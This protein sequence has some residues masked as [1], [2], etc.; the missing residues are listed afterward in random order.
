MIA[1]GFAGGEAEEVL[2]AHAGF[3]GL[4]DH[5]HLFVRDQ[6]GGAG[7]DVAERPAADHVVGQGGF[8]L[9]GIPHKAH[10]GMEMRF[11]QAEEFFQGF[12]VA[13]VLMQRVLKAELLAIQRLRPLG[14]L[15][16]AEDP[17]FHVLR[18]DHE[19]AE[20]RDDDVVDLGGA[21]GGGQGDVVDVDA[22]LAVQRDFL[23]KCQQAFA[24]PS[25]E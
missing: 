16:V 13:V 8:E 19:D 2:G 6:H 18:F 17:A 15:R 9:A 24:H 4:H 3:D 20:A 12:G 25:L 7:L 11:R 23:G 1:F 5:G 22:H 14:L 10:Y 21:V